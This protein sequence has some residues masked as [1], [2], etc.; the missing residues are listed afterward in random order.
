MLLSTLGCTV[1]RICIKIVHVVKV[2]RVKVKYSRCAQLV[3]ALRYCLSTYNIKPS[4]QLA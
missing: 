4:L 3:L 1:V 2:L